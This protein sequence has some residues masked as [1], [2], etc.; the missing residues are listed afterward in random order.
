MSMIFEFIS[1]FVILFA[2]SLIVY[3]V[4]GLLLVSVSKHYP[5]CRI[6]KNR[7]GMK[8]ARLEIYSSIKALGVSA[9]L[10]ST[11]FFFQL[12]GWVL[13]E[14]LPL[15]WWSFAFSFFVIF[16]LFDAWFYWGHRLLH[17]KTFYR[18]H[19][20]HHSSIAPTAW[21]NDSSAV[22]DTVIEHG[23][24]FVVW[25]L[26]PVPALAVFALRLFDQVS[27]MIGHSGF[28]YFAG[29]GSRK[30][31]PF[32]CTIFHDLHHSQFHYNFGNFMSL[33]DRWMGTMHPNYDAIVRKIETTG[34]I[35][36]EKSTR[37]NVKS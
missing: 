27:G 13:F 30:P 28:E 6:Q 9:I 19:K 12:Q 33:W 17:L 8:R 24:Y 4:T 7:D 23:F 1:I 26:L 15:N 21:S 3:F 25:V 16:I 5:D 20:P 22:M 14:P 11:G 18:W 29:R 10:F 34:E 36:D 31:S 35:P 32:I 2:I 37:V